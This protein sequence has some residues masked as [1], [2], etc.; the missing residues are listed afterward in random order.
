MMQW[1]ITVVLALTA[2]AT[3]EPPPP[4]GVHDTDALLA[5][6][7][8]RGDELETL[9]ADVTLTRID[10]LSG[11]ETTR[12]GKLY[13]DER[14]DTALFRVSLG[15]KVEEG[16]TFP[17]TATDF[18]LRGNVL[19]ERDHGAKR[20]IYR[21]LAEE[22]ETVDLF[23]LGTGPLPLPIGQDPVEVKK[24][25][26]I[27]DVADPAEG[28]EG[29]PTLA[30]EPKP[31]QELSKRFV[32]VELWIDPALKMPR[33][34]IVVGVDDIQTLVLDNVVINQDIAGENFNI[35]APDQ[36]E[37]EIRDE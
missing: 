33:Q 22:G 13:L 6:L 12:S 5:M 31:E 19:E 11:L 18:I 3:V 20:I 35:E 25:F 9:T 37:W 7:D 4:A 23:A 16:N 8:E 27:A 32:A 34:V 1:V 14:G 15:D 2:C 30:L 29:L 26:T 21:K 24:V 10:M 17:G 28:P 36:A